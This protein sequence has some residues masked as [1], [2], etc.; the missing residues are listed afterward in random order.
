MN[1]SFKIQYKDENGNP[2]VSSYKYSSIEAFKEFLKL[3]GVD[4]SKVNDMRK[5]DDV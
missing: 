3:Y 2:K 5:S 1:E 4:L